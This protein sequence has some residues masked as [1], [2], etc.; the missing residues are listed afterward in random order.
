MQ[1]SGGLSYARGVREGEGDRDLPEMPPLRSRLAL[2]YAAKSWFAETEGVAARAQHRVDSTLLETPTAGYATW[3]VK[4]GIH[5]SRLRLAAGIDNLLDRFYHEHFSFQR[6]PFRTG[7]R[8]PE[9]GRAVFVTL[10]YGF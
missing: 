9:P 8:V 7:V 10:G 3:N 1:L 6:D 5:S 2:R 4:A